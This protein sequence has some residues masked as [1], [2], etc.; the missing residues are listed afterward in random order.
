[1]YMLKENQFARNLINTITHK[2]LQEKRDRAKPPMYLEKPDNFLSKREGPYLVQRLNLV[3]TPSQSGPDSV[4]LKGHYMGSSEYEVGD[5]G[6]ALNAMLRSGFERSSATIQW[7]GQEVPV[8]LLHS[9]LAP[10]QK[11]TF[12]KNFT[13]FLQQDSLGTSRLKESTHFH[14]V[15]EEMSNSEPTNMNRSQSPNLWMDFTDGNC[16]YYA[17]DQEVMNKLETYLSKKQKN[18][19]EATLSQDRGLVG[20]LVLQA[21]KIFLGGDTELQ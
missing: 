1:M 14:Y 17:L 19:I 10:D 13:A 2:V 8:F 4:L 9:K 21:R 15:L 16:I 7:N 12:L 20:K 3:S 11:I 5:Q 18:M 6:K